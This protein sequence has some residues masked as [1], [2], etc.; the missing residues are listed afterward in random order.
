MMTIVWCGD[1]GARGSVFK[2]IQYLRNGN[3]NQNKWRG[4]QDLLAENCYRTTDPDHTISW[5][6]P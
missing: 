4:A 6:D 3:Y 2:I 1:S 5:V